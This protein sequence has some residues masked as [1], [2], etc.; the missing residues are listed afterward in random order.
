MIEI[1]PIEGKIDA[2]VTIPG[3]KSYTN[4]ALL[5]SALADGRSILKHAL[6][7]DDTLYMARAL[8]SLGHEVGDDRSA[9]TFEVVG[10][11]GQI[12]VSKAE[13]FIGN[14]GTAARFLTSYLTLGSG[15][16]SIDGVERMRQRPIDD[17]LDGLW[18]L[19]ANVS[20]KF[21]N[22]CPPVL[23]EANGLPGGKAVVNAQKSS[24]FLS[25]IL[26]SAPYAK[27]DVEL[28]IADQIVSKPYIDITLSV[29]SS[30]GVDVQRDGYKRFF[31]RSGRRYCA[32][33]YAIEPDASSA[34]YFFA[35]AALVGGRVRVMNLTA[36]S[37]QGDA[38]FVEILRQMG[39]EVNYG[40]DFIEVI[41]RGK[42]EGVE[43]D[44]NE[45]SDTA[46]TLAAI[47]PFAKDRVVIKNIGH[48][49]RK[50]TDRIAAIVNELRR[51]KV[52]VD[53]LEDGLIVYPSEVQPASIETYDDHRM[54]M[55]FAVIGLKIPGVKIK[56]PEC[57]SKTFPNFFD[58]LE[59]SLGSG[60][61]FSG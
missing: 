50:E 5:A 25:S 42:L 48:I 14:A 20:T 16:Y 54:A 60:L 32:R 56:D 8:R 34:S 61:H 45:I 15:E 6:F 37:A 4:R 57:V 58:K 40:D 53:E 17:L 28:E 19:G 44:M 35:A 43:V 46:Q 36:D 23:I 38:R 52:K 30:F 21:G 29:M 13:L 41:G 33:E 59:N 49:R 9:A 51:L 31:V 47:A 10:T 24:Q 27:R 22:G 26:L 3:S 7:S 11:G 39:C 12:P 1:K 2:T 18:Q 55:S